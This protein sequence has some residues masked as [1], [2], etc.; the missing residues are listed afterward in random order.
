MNDEWFADEEKVRRTVGLLENPT[1]LPNEK[2]VVNFS[3]TENLDLC[4][5]FNR[6]Y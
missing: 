2:E 4:L 5:A 1:P 6:I 3:T